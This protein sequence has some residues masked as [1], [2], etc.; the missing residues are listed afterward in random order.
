MLKITNLEREE[1]THK[2]DIYV[3]H[4]CCF[5]NFL[6]M[7]IMTAWKTQIV[8]PIIN[9]M[10]NNNIPRAPVPT[11]IPAA[12]LW[13][14]SGLVVSEHLH[15]MTDKSWRAFFPWKSDTSSFN[16]WC[17]E[18][19]F[20]PLTRLTEYPANPKQIWVLLCY[21][22]NDPLLECLTKY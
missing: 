7:I 5:W 8:L 18:W 11:V 13:L 14:Q 21:G 19:T 2:Y 4:C 12:F 20:C 6:M 3:L 16:L 15:T 10:Q 9:V 22:I 17:P 1:N